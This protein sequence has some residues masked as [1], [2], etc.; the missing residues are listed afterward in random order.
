MTTTRNIIPGL[1]NFKKP[2]ESH[3]FHNRQRLI[4][5]SNVLGCKSKE[6]GAVLNELMQNT[7]FFVTA[8]EEADVVEICGALKVQTSLQRSS[9]NEPTARIYRTSQYPGA[10]NKPQSQSGAVG[11]LHSRLNVPPQHSGALRLV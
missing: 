9:I 6:H 7:H 11:N 2:S 4:V 1:Q 5:K 10:G 8:V 3:V